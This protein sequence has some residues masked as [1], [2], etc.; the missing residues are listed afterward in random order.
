MSDNQGCYQALGKII[1]KFK[2]CGGSS[3]TVFTKLFNTAVLLIITYSAGIWG[4]KEYGQLDT[5][6]N[7]VG[8]FLLS[9]PPSTSNV[10][11]HGEMGWDSV[12]Y[13]SRLAIVRTYCRIQSMEN[14]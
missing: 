5:V 2:N 3:L 12:I 7:K 9:V 8:H 1:A 13:H 4:L 14:D 6:M 10:A 11:T